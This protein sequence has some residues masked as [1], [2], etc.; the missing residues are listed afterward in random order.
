MVDSTRDGVEDM[1]K[2]DFDSLNLGDLTEAWEL[3]EEVVCI[4]NNVE[5]FY[6]D[7]NRNLN[8]YT[9]II[10]SDTALAE[11]PSKY[12]EVDITDLCGMQMMYKNEIPWFVGDHCKYTSW[13]WQR[14]INVHQ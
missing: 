5:T 3:D 12:K 11:I 9:W 8:L 13:K 14:K 2:T 10:Q 4:I 6:F 7:V 1:S